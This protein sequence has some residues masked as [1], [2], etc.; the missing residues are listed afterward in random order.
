M[1]QVSMFWV[2]A[3]IVLAYSLCFGAEFSP[4]LEFE[5]E[6]AKSDEFVSAIVI[7]ESP[8]DI[9]T[10]DFRLHEEKGRPGPSQSRSA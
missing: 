10:L 4:E 1:K 7:L 6:Q 2:A 3:G 9:R 5:L 8:I